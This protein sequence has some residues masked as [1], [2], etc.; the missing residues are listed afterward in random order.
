M[1]VIK[2]SGYVEVD[3]SSD[4]EYEHHTNNKAQGQGQALFLSPADSPSPPSSSTNSS[5]GG[6]SDDE[7]EKDHKKEGSS[8]ATPSTSKPRTFSFTGS[9][10]EILS[11]A[12]AAMRQIARKNQIHSR[13]TGVT[14]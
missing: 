10:V 6:S 14:Q 1:V 13:D 4:E 8:R 9:G 12:A 3:D 5:S 2:S 7:E 11:P